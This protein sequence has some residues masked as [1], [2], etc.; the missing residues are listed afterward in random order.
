MSRFLLPLQVVIYDPEEL[1]IFNEISKNNHNNILN[2]QTGFKNNAHYQF[3]S[4][5]DNTI[6]RRSMLTL[7]VRKNK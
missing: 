5:S 4:E 1:H 6:T 3:V 2:A 7:K